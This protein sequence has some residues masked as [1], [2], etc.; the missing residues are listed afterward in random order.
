[1]MLAE[2]SVVAHASFERAVDAHFEGRISS[3]TERRMRAHLGTCAS[4]RAYYE[5]H[6]TLAAVDPQGARPLA[7]RM[8][9][10]LGL[11][12]PSGAAAVDLRR[13]GLL[14]ALPAVALVVLVAFVRRGDVD[15]GSG[16]SARGGRPAGGQ[17]LISEIDAIARARQ[18]TTVVARDSGLAFAYA[19]LGHKR[20]LLVFGVDEHRNVYW[21]Y[22]AWSDAR[23]NPTA[24]PIVK[25]DAVHE[26]PEAV[27][28]HFASDRLQVFAVFTDRAMSVRD[29]EAA[30][31]RAGDG[32]AGGVRLA[33]PGSDVA[34]ARLHLGGGR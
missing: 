27:R 28:H 29:I 2:S 34:E 13:A 7:E 20:R 33:L 22:P 3:A 8:A 1:M 9:R 31:A 26:L 25:D 17:L 5:R 32:E 12:A 6:L 21:F 16:S 19:N 4:C 10:G 14:L 30:V 18:V 24:V 15:G 11:R 23:D